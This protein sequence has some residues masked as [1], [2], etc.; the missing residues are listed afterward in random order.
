[1]KTINDF[2]RLKSA[3]IACAAE[4]PAAVVQWTWSA[5]I[6]ELNHNPNFAYQVC[7]SV[8]ET[9][10]RRDL[11]RCEAYG[12]EMIAIAQE[13]RLR[14]LIRSGDNIIV[15]TDFARQGVDWGILNLGGH[16]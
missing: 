6:F 4:A 5:F 1:M 14:N 16:E 3:V 15:E 11:A 12:R 13:R 7:Y 2:E 8:A 10:C 9:L